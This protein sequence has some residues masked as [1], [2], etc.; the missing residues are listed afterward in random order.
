MDITIPMSWPGI[1]AGCLLVF[2]PAMGEYVIPAMLGGPDSLMIGRQLFN[3]FY[4][5]R[6]WPVAS[7][8]AAILL[9]LLVVPMMLLNRYQS[10]DLEQKQ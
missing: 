1:V 7:A 6:D 8:V 10:A 2:I 4:D 9:V 3:E 5:N